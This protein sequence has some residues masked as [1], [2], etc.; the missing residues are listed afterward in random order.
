MLH[1]E[2]VGYAGE[3]RYLGRDVLGYISGWVPAKFQRFAS[4][5]IAA[6]MLLRG[7]DLTDAHQVMFHDDPG[8]NNMMFQHGRPA[9]F[10]D[11]DFAAPAQCWRTSAIWPRHGMSANP[12][13]GARRI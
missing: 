9:A 6:A 1:L 13:R 10:I 3:P 12:A 2:S 11:F 7:S 5:Q 8:P 4:G